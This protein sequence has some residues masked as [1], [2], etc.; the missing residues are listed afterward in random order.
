V[1]TLARLR[2]DERPR[3]PSGMAHTLG[4]GFITGASNDDPSSIGTYSQVGAQFGYGLAWT[5]LFTYPLLVA[6]QEI[7]ARLGRVT[8]C[9]I[10]GN[11]ERHYPRWFAVSLVGLLAVA[12]VINLAADLGAMGAVLRLVLDAPP[13]L[14]VCLLALVCVLF[15]VFTRYARYVQTLKWLCVT[16]LSYVVGAFVV[17]VRWRDVA[18]A[19]LWPPL[20]ATPQ[21]L[22]AVVAALGT[23]ISPYLLFWQAQQEVERGR[24]APGAQ[25][26]LG[27]LQQ[28]PAEFARIRID[29]AI[30]MG[31][32]SLVALFIVITTASTLHAQGVH[33]IQ[34]AAEAA[35]ALRA[36]G[37]RFTL[38]LFALG[39]TGAGLLALPAL[40]TSAAYAVGE[41]LTWR[42]GRSHP[43]GRARAFYAVVAAAAAIGCA[44]NFSPVNPMRALYFSAILNGVAAIPL[45]IV[46][47]HLSTRTA[48]V[49]PLKLPVGVR[50]L[51]W[52]ATLAMAVSVAAMVV[53]WLL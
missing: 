24:H 36:V 20:S 19:L 37:G 34:T 5:L 22:T 44:L 4:P 15:E 28:A 7:S 16:L 27:N 12:N 13:L 38:L 6:V 42:V 52:A 8:G 1:D 39:I 48:V 40:S 10:A 46:L 9:G 25:P 29:T 43:A 49:G 50:A 21:Y 17:D 33:T 2:R 3:A 32:S 45:I 30:G 31:L 11:L 26:L 53:S 47:M 51:G 14:Y 23:T 41:L 35:E 18:H